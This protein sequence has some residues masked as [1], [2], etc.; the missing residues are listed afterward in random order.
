MSHHARRH[1]HHAAHA[2]PTAAKLREFSLTLV[3]GV[4]STVG[5]AAV[6]FVVCW[7]VCRATRLR[8]TWALVLMPLPVCIAALA[9]PVRL[10]GVGG[11][12]F[13]S[14][15][16]AG[17]LAAAERRDELHGG[18]LRRR[19]RSK[20][21]PLQV[22][23][24]ATRRRA[25]LRGPLAAIDLVG[26]RDWPRFW[27]RRGGRFA[28]GMAR[29]SHRPVWLSFGQFAKH[30]LI[31]GAT[32][33]GKSN[34]LSWVTT[35]AIRAGYGA[36]V[37]D[38]KADPALRE[39]LAVEAGICGRPF[40]VW[41]IEGGGQQ[42]NPLSAGDSTARRDRLTASQ[43]FSEDYYRGLFSAHAKVVLDALAGAGREVTLATVCESWDPEDL[44]DLIRSIDDDTA[45]DRLIAYLDRLPRGQA[46][47]VVSLRARLA[48]VTDTT[49]GE[50][51]QGGTCEA[52]RIDL[53]QA[54]RRRAVVVFSVN[55]DA[56]PGAAAIIGNLI[57]QDLVGTVGAFRQDRERAQSVIAVDEFGA[58]LG[59]QLGRLLSTARD[60]GLPTV[61]AGQD[62]SQLRRVS[63]HFEAEVKANV[64]VV[65][66]HRQSEPNSAEQI[67]RICGTEQVVT[68]TQQVDRRH[69][70]WSAGASRTE[71][72]TGSQH[73]ERQ[74]RVE[75]DE[76][77]DLGT[78]EAVVRAWN[79]PSVDVVRMFRCETADDAAA[80]ASVTEGTGAVR[81][82]TVAEVI[83]AADRFRGALRAEA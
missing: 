59:E 50:R 77:K 47:H 10:A 75:P 28:V 51:L 82:A 5:A 58:L 14:V 63:E 45:R 43:T 1:H 54:L 11:A 24:A 49:A 31:L 32:G 18:R 40:Y 12:V 44:K 34:T 3:Q 23:L 4:G 36:I 66:A 56:Y 21:G 83:R 71:T 27:R 46:E 57:L 6:A 64:S 16:A 20:R 8:W 65:I 62:L 48:E 67:A 17:A 53:A 13:G 55:S 9:A 41:R 35:R 7:L 79:P 38:L 2:D 60:V 70:N 73:H 19:A 42:Y 25:V 68:Q 39:R 78:G 61:L 29:T 52:D 30:I 80:L 15:V 76:V 26:P 22:L 81:R 74:F 33:S 69:W 37:L 72:G